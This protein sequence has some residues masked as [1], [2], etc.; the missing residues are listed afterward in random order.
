MKVHHR[1]FSIEDGPVVY[2]ATAFDSRLRGDSVPPG[3]SPT[4]SPNY[5]KVHGLPSKPGGFCDF[6]HEGVDLI[7]F[8]RSECETLFSS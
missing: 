5:K 6:F 7:C 8:Q 3:S 4:K 2:P 1:P